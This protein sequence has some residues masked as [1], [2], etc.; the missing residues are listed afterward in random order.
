[1][2]KQFESFNLKNFQMENFNEEPQW[3]LETESTSLL[4]TLNGVRWRILMERAVGTIALAGLKKRSNDQWTKPQKLHAMENSERIMIDHDLRMDA[5]LYTATTPNCLALRTSNAEW[6][7]FELELVVGLHCKRRFILE[8]IEKVFKTLSRLY[9]KR[10]TKNLNIARPSMALN[11]VHRAGLG[12]LPFEWCI[13]YR[14]MN[15]AIYRQLVS[16][17]RYFSRCMV[18]RF[19]WTIGIWLRYRR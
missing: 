4:E 13:R 19:R 5:R 1:M 15:W 7:F 9:W 6:P 18:N 11:R 16:W 17:D 10:K 12:E 2:F 14:L 3:E 8:N